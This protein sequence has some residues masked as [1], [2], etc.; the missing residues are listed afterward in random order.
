M[1]NENS[2]G[3]A[4]ASGQQQREAMWS[5]Q[6]EARADGE[7]WVMWSGKEERK[8]Y[9]STNEA[10]VHLQRDDGSKTICG[11]EAGPYWGYQIHQYPPEEVPCDRCRAAARKRYT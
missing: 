1:T 10:P 8:R 6:D 9:G 5:G 11:I 4:P 3:D 7:C 2:T